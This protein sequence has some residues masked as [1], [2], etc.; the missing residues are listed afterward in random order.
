MTP[1]PILLQTSSACLYPTPHPSTTTA[2]PNLLQKSVIHLP[3]IRYLTAPQPI[4][5]FKWSG[6]L[7]FSSY[8]PGVL[9]LCEMQSS[10]PSGPIQIKSAQPLHCQPAAQVPLETIQWLQQIYC[11]IWGTQPDSLEGQ[12]GRTSHAPDTEGTSKVQTSKGPSLQTYAP[13]Q[14]TRSGHLLF[15]SRKIQAFGSTIMTSLQDG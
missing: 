12:R 6:G 3:F 10:S 15:F 5:F 7:L 14:Q 11:H 2:R 9:P 13:P 8:L 4:C 1:L